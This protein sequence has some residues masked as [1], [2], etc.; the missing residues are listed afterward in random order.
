MSVRRWRAVTRSALVAIA[1]VAATV[2]IL[3]GWAERTVFQSQEFADRATAAL[4][5][6]AVRTA[7]AEELAD[8]LVE[9]GVGS[10]S[11]FRSVLVPLLE[12]VE[13]TPAFHQLFRAAL[14][15]VH[16]AVFQRHA[17]RALLEL[18]DTLSILTST[19]KGAH[20]DLV[21]RLPAEATSLLVDVSPTL[22][23]IKP[24]RIAQDF[25]WLDDAAWIVSVV[26]V[27]GALV[28]DPRR[29]RTV[30]WLGVATVAVGVSVVAVTTA[31]PGLAAQ[32]LRDEG[33]A[34]AAR[35]GVR[36]FMADLRLI[37]LWLIPVG[38]VVA[39]GATATGAPHLLIDGRRWWTRGRMW[40]AGAGRPARTLVGLVLIAVGAGVV[41]ARDEVLPVTL[42]LA[43]AF[44]AYLGVALFVTALL[45]TVDADVTDRHRVRPL[46]RTSAAAV[47]VLTVSLL[48][49]LVAT[50]AIRD[51]GR[52]AR[53]SSVLKC[54]GSASLCS[55]RLDQVAFPG[56]HNSMSAA[57]DP[58][59]L[60]AE[61]LRGIPAQ[62]AYGIRA[63]LVKTH[64][65]IPTGLDVGGHELVVTDRADEIAADEPAEVQELSPTVVAKAQEL[66]ED[67]AERSVRA[68]RL[69]VPR[70]LLARRDE[71][72]HG[73]R[74][75]QDIHGSEPQ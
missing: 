74:R 63:L 23:V 46:I 45:G 68:R 38:V 10:L 69:S 24:W 36:L 53:A 30:L 52:D 18:G 2:A 11:S 50:T 22:H 19:A 20:D 6:P 49:V 51:A 48:A 41:V 55:K 12:D 29:R 62:L 72:L 75:H 9:A 44:V 71:I 27:A 25:R 34:E 1:G 5:S 37:G 64:Y 60:F 35:H 42:T 32:Q 26:A 58:G 67:D 28:V 16:S 39:A 17:S 21:G 14:V 4:D 59:W 57:L 40:L 66:E 3:A 65:G 61:N 13:Q 54:N 33:L 31:V 15:E 47:I 70:V 73:A 8:R 7:L 56:S 43:G